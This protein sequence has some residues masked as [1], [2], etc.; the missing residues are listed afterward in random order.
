MYFSDISK[1]KTVVKE[2]KFKNPL[3]Q[4]EVFANTNLQT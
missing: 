3:E 1:M 2:K 4:L